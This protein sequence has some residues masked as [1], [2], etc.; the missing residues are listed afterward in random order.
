MPALGG[1]K[2]LHTTA[3]NEGRAWAVSELRLAGVDSDTV[4][5]PVVVSR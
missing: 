1:G 2:V 3:R 5:V 4:V